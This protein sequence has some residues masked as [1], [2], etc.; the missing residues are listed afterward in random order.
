MEAEIYTS[1]TDSWRKVEISVES[2]S[3][4]IFLFNNLGKRCIFVNGALHFIAYGQGYDFILSFDVDDERFREIK[5]P[6]NYS[7]GFNLRSRQL[8]VYKGSLALIVFCHDPANR[9]CICLKWE[10]KEYGV[11]ESW[12]WTKKCITMDSFYSCYGCID[13]GEILIKNANGLVSFDPENHQNIMLLK[14]HVGRI[15]LL[16]LWRVWFYLMGVKV[17]LNTK[18]S[19]LNFLERLL[20]W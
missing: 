14:M 3:G 7:S 4:P 6:Q 12:T 2:L 10:M 9:G 19:L 8:E 16:I 13:N 5:L 17:Y 18:I 11:A 15:T 1:S 20:F